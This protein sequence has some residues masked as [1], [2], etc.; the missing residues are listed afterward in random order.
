MQELLTQVKILGMGITG[1]VNE[2]T[3]GNHFAA[4]ALLAGIAYALRSVPA[5]IYGHVYKRLMRSY[6]IEY[7]TR[8]ECPD[9]HLAS[10]IENQ[11]VNG[12]ATV[13]STRL[14]VRNRKVFM[15]IPSGS[16]VVFSRGKL[17]LVSRTAGNKDKEGEVSNII[18][19][20]F[21]WNAD[22]IKSILAEYNKQEYGPRVYVSA[23]EWR[24][25]K[26]IEVSKLPTNQFLSINADL[27]KKIDK[28]L[29]NFVNNKKWYDD[30]GKVR[31]LNMLLS[32]IP[33][34]GKTTI[35]E[36]VAR[37]LNT[38]LFMFGESELTDVFEYIKEARVLVPHGEVPVILFD[39]ID[40]NI[41]GLRR[42]LNEVPK[43]DET[44]EQKQKREDRK[45]QMRQ[46]STRNL[47]KMLALLQSTASP[48]DVVI[49]MTTND[50]DALDEAIFR[51]G[52]IHL[53]AEVNFM[54]REA[55]L[56]F[57]TK[58]YN[59]M[60]VTD[61]DM[62]TI[63]AC[64]LSNANGKYPTDVTEFLA[65]IHA[66]NERNKIKFNNMIATNEEEL[67]TA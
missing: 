26:W 42:L 7:S 21:F 46:A 58:A 19:T 11:I 14:F 62:S 36:Y 5:K 67:E 43:K 6:S 54:D 45:E 61:K 13:F 57:M 65:D 32:G 12:M 44:P 23:K 31:T 47:G 9:S 20:T 66:A 18:I 34:T 17:L 15:A 4:A 38:S 1:F 3:G 27:K 37:R 53:D 56:E 25:S 33:G 24:H 16:R 64:D 51:P 2:L 48:P 59:H 28:L 10:F 55:V 63:R 29:D 41:P 30:V 50:K 40:A 8:G 52:R 35:A 39:D 49:V 22:Y 60:Y